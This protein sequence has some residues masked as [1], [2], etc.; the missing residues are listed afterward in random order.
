VKINESD[1]LQIEK[2]QS[3]RVT[4]TPK[5]GSN[6]SGPVTTSTTGSSDGIDLG[7][8]LALLSQALQSGADERS[9]RVDQ[10]K[11]LVQSGQY[12]V[13]SGALSESIVGAA[14]NGY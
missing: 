8:Q 10:L 7:S 2:P 1:P 4:S 13:D 12:Q 11:A 6:S 3:E 5:T 9:S 14:L